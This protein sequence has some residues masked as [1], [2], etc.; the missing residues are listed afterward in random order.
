MQIDGI[1]TGG[2][3][4]DQL[5]WNNQLLYKRQTETLPFTTHVFN[6]SDVNDNTDQE[7]DEAIYKP[8]K[9]LDFT[10]LWRDTNL[11]TGTGAFATT[12][13]RFWRRNNT[14]AGIKIINNWDSSWKGD[15]ILYFK[16]LI[17]EGEGVQI[18]WHQGVTTD[19]KYIGKGYSDDDVKFY[20]FWSN[21]NLLGENRRS[22]LNYNYVKDGTTFTENAHMP[23]NFKNTDSLFQY[24]RNQGIIHTPSFPVLEDSTYWDDIKNWDGTEWDA[25]TGSIEPTDYWTRGKTLRMVLKN[26]SNQTLPYYIY[27][28]FCSNL[29]SGEAGDYV[30]A[31]FRDITITKLEDTE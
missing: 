25:S 17:P 11:D 30:M 2:H 26:T 1:Q 12:Y 29:N 23:I 27:Y 19:Y 13:K 10:G 31:G 22:G 15:I 8:N 6:G 24:Y 28:S 20:L 21:Y 16:I 4:V 9:Y 18:D 5:R 7:M 3:K 14:N